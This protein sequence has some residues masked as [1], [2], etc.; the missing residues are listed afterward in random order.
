MTAATDTP[1]SAAA[2]A[3]EPAR[4]TF[5]ALGTTAV[6]LVAD[7]ARAGAALQV[8]RAEL[9]AIDTACSRFRPDSELS[10][11]NAGAG[12]G[13]PVP[14]GALLAEAVEVA[15]RAARLTGGAVDPTVGPAL[16]A[17]GYDTTF[18]RVAPSGPAP[19][20]RPAGGWR[21]V[22][23]DPALRL[24]RLPAGTALDLGATAKALAADRAARTAAAAAGCGV[25]VN[26]GG[27]LSAA[28]HPPEG[29]W[30]I[31]IAD[32]HAGP[33]FPGAP[34]VSLLG[35]GMAT[36]GTT[37]RAWQRGGRT[38]HH[39]VDPATGDSA[40]EVWRTVTVAAADCVDANTASTAAV[41]LGEH[42]V[43]WLRD[44]GLP[45][46]LVRTDGRVVCL[47]GWSDDTRH[48]WEKGP[49]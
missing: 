14:V 10:R 44:T 31:A 9:A 49:R 17:L 34:V 21:G 18:T 13:R 33:A 11:A 8:L 36:S 1:P 12:S 39:I 19:E 15:L 22:G 32:D 4:V 42:A 40:P 2:P 16:V 48:E 6:L 20:L 23:W 7:P 24:L 35:G 25:L 29:G 38:R 46:R 26:L 3:G 30:R 5:P 27:D 37:V 28:G 47:G 41:V 45:A 43:P